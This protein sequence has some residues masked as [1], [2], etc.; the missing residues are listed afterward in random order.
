MGQ[1]GGEGQKKNI[2]DAVTTCP[3]LAG[4]VPD[5]HFKD[6]K[7]VNSK[8]V[9]PMHYA[10][11]NYGA[12]SAEVS[13]F[14]GN[15]RQTNPPYYFGY[16]PPPG[17]ETDPVEKAEM[18]KNPPRSMEKVK[19][20]SDE[21]MV[22]DAWYRNVSGTP[23]VPQQAGPYQSGWSGEALPYFAP[24]YR[25]GTR[26]VPTDITARNNLA[27]TIGPKAKT[28]GRTPTVYFDTHASAVT[29]KVLKILRA[30]GS[31]FGPGNLYGFS[32][33]VNMPP[34]TV[35]YEWE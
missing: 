14:T 31:L 2:T 32:G 23:L 33:T 4:I 3:A 12:R 13:G 21:W 10:I 20:A 8:S 6:F 7:T 26:E 30:D 22:A 17:T 35:R 5:Q 34:S 19:R 25:V 27:K 29:S 18:Q 11:N 1:R 15:V 28:D 9:M 24:H 16:S